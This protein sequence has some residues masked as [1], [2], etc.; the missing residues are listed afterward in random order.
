M[1]ISF[2]ATNHRSLRER[3]ELSLVAER[4]PVAEGRA[5]FVVPHHDLE[6]VPV[7]ALVGANGSGKSNV[8]DALGFAATA[9]AESH[10]RWSAT[11]SPHRAPFQTIDG[12]D[13]S[14]SVYELTFVISG[15]V[16]EYEFHISA[17]AIEFEQLLMSPQGPRSRT[18]LYSREAGPGGAARFSFGRRLSGPRAAAE[19]ATRANS[20]FLA[21][22]AQNN[23]PLLT[24]V[25]RWIAEDCRTATPHDREERAVYTAWK[26]MQ[27]DDRYRE[28]LR[29]F[30]AS[31]DLGISDLTVQV[32]DSTE[33]GLTPQPT[34]VLGGD[35]A[36]TA[37]RHY[38]VT[39][40]H[41]GEVGELDLGEESSGTRAWFEWAAPII[42]MVEGGSVLGA[43]ELDAHLNEHLAAHAIGAFQDAALNRHGA[44]LLFTTQDT[45]VLSRAEL[46][47]DQIWVTEKSESGSTALI[48][49]TDFGPRRDWDLGRA[50]RHGRFGGIPVVDDVGL[51]AALTDAGRR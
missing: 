35:A 9:V 13:E 21:S 7:V 39:F 45:G 6:V 10:T 47:R 16:Y 36:A 26:F 30:L 11:A 29:S 24:P 28:R 43:D 40:R 46:G 8:L 27:G 23:H 20:L 38:R 31:A 48:P 14:A 50:F 33:R 32:V 12:P 19:A 3:C 49:F 41:R 34:Q 2:A 22:A 44:Q 42:E 51:A 4:R 25:W 37:K 17:D 1:L 5:A 18:R 15:V